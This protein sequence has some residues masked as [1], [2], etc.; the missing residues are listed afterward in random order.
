ME[1][2]GLSRHIIGLLKATRDGRMRFIVEHELQQAMGSG[3]SSWPVGLSV[4][5]VVSYTIQHEA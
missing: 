2:N 5:R 1:R 4:E 3:V